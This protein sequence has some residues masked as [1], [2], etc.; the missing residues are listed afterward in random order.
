MAEET[1]LDAAYAADTPVLEPE[2][3]LELLHRSPGERET[4]EACA[5]F[6]Q[7]AQQAHYGKRAIGGRHT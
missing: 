6:M 1:R 3:V 4:H 7:F 2:G 5:C